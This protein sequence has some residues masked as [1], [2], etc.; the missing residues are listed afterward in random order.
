MGLLS[1]MVR[2]GRGIP[3]GRGARRTGGPGRR[4]PAMRGPGDAGVPADVADGGAGGQGV[5]AARGFRGRHGPAGGC[6]RGVTAG[7]CRLPAIGRTATWAAS[8]LTQV[9]AIR[10]REA[11]IAVLGD[12]LEL[13]RSG[14]RAVVLIEGEAGIGKTRLLDA[15]LEDARRRGMQ[16]AAGRAEELEGMRRPAVHIAPD[17][18]DR[19]A[20]VFAKLDLTSRA[21][22]A[23]EAARRGT[24]LARYQR[25]GRCSRPPVTAC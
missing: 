4:G 13:A 18:A 16:V 6:L 24:A 10:G 15:A 22:L 23:A 1:G 8:T 5:Q 21:Q 14:R 19:P 2:V 20:H 11:E 3:A 9:S 12:A 25:N 7:I 17:G